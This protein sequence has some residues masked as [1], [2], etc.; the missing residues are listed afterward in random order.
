M[1]VLQHRRA[2]VADAAA[3]ARAFGAKVRRHTPLR[4]E[5]RRL[6]SELTITQHERTLTV[7][8][9]PDPAVVPLALWSRSDETGEWIRHATLVAAGDRYTATLD[10]GALPRPLGLPQPE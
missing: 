5:R 1:S 7:V 3:A 2:R 4:G 10:L 8:V 6:L 9:V